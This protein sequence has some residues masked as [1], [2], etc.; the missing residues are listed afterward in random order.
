MWM[1]RFWTWSLEIEDMRSL[2]VGLGNPIMGDDA[3]GCRCAEAIET[4]LSPQELDMVEVI[5]FFRGGIS[6]MER[7]IGY[8]RV[9]IIDSITGS[10]LNPGAVKKLTLDEI[11]S[12]T[13]NSPHDGSLKNALEFGKLMGAELPR[14]VDILA[15]EIEPKFEFSDQL[16][17]PVEA[18]IPQ[19][20]QLALDW[21]FQEEKVTDYS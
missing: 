11:P 8:D 7:L 19:V 3:I 15:V 1:D 6:L 4:A 10:G 20:L 17:A 9:L 13:V 14:Q 21:I 16:S 18:G 12:Y 5:Q 2:I